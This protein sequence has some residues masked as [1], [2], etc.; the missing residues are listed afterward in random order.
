MF[1]LRQALQFLCLKM[2][3]VI[4]KMKPTTFFPTVFA[5]VQVY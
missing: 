2:D 3:G 1:D 5:S 4:K